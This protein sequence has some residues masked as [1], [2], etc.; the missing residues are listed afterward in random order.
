MHTDRQVMHTDRNADRQVM[1]TD[2]NAH[3]QVMHTDRQ[4]MQSDAG[5]ECR[6]LC[7]QWTLGRKN[8][9]TDR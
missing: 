6:L 5:R 2:R 3:R 8:V 7:L 1:H 9:G 4:V